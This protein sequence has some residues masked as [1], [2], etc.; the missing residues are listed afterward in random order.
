MEESKFRYER[1][2]LNKVNI[3]NDSGC[4]FIIG[5]DLG[6]FFIG[7]YKVLSKHYPQGRHGCYLI[8][9]SKSQ[10]GP[11]CM[12]ISNWSWIFNLFQNSLS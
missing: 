1:L 9:Q 8:N 5:D 12:G 3:T 2:L 7:K 11:K 4:F 6:L 10:D